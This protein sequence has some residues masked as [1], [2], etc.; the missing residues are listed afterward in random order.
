ML[1]RC[2]EVGGLFFT[3]D[4]NREVDFRLKRGGR[5]HLSECK[6]TERAEARD[7]RGMTYA[8]SGR[9]AWHLVGGHAHPPW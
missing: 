3:R 1:E 4:R 2:G 7:L 8:A 9:S 5:F 6:W